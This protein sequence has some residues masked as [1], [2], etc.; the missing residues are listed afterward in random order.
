MPN[1]LQSAVLA[2]MDNIAK[3]RIERLQ[4]DKTVTATVVQCNNSLTGEYLVSYQG[5]NIVAYSQDGTAYSKNASVYVLV[6]EGN[7]SNTKIILGYAVALEDDMNIT[8][9]SS[10]INDYDII[11]RNVIRHHTDQSF[12]L[13]SYLAHDS[14]L[15]YDYN[16]Q[17][18][19]EVDIDIDEFRNYVLDAEAIIES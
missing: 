12:G 16:D 15:I 7:F 10:L 19:N 18:N 5:G 9:V 3:D 2:A 4:T 17:S 13:H 11:G 6:P 8:F 1:E 14:Y